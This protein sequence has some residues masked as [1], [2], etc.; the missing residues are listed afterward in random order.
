MDTSEIK[1]LKAKCK[2]TGRYYG[3]ELRQRDGEWKAV[4]MVWLSDDERAIIDSEVR[5]SR[6]LSA[7]NLQPCGKCGTRK[8]FSCSC[9]R[10]KRACSLSSPY[11]LDCIYCDQ[12]E[13]DYSRNRRRGPY[14]EWAGHSNIPQAIKDKYGNPQGSQYDLAEDGAFTGY[15]IVLLNLCNECNF[16]QPRVA[17]EKKGFKITEFTTLPPISTLKPLLD[18]D[19][20]QLWI[21]SH[22]VPFMNNDYV[23]LIC[24]YFYSG[25][26][27]YIWGDNDPYYQDAN[28]I[29]QRLFGSCLYGDYIG[30]QVLGIQERNNQPGIIA[31]HP[32]TTGIASF[33]EGITISTVS[34]TGGLSPL[35]YNSECNV[36]TAYYD[37]DDRRVLVDGGFTRLCHRWDTAGTDRYIVN[38]AS[39]L[40]NIERFGYFPD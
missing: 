11:E 17:L 22:R 39:W 26:G 5:Q 7:D 29:L 28:L 30:Q 37:R 10:G 18:D 8:L 33:F 12:L 32:I 9:L 6:F 38:A 21:V 40:T 27:V 13:I 31:N 34:L 35:I 23:T 15:S 2:R 1:M 4:N 16:N 36:V 20:S 3:I 14:T 25:H 24:N 19:R